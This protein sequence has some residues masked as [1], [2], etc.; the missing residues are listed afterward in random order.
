MAGHPPVACARV[1]GG[2]EQAVA[3]DADRLGVA[4]RLVAGR[5][6]PCPAN[7]RTPGL[8][9]SRPTIRDVAKAAGVSVTTVSHALNG[10]GRVDPET[11]ALVSHG[12]PV[13]TIEQ[14]P[15]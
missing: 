14:G 15:G 8:M 11:R 6:R 5:A 4:E 3:G 7:L 12:L 2:G 10:K 13:V 1:G 9:V